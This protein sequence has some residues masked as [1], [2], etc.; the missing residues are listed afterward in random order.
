[1]KL[2]LTITLFF[3]FTSITLAQEKRV[4]I[5]GLVTSNNLAVENVHV[6]NSNNGF[7]EVT[8]F[9]GKFEILTNKGDTIK[10]S[11]IEYQKQEIVITDDIIKNGLAIILK[12]TINRLKEVTVRNH[13]L[14]RNIVID[15]MN[16]DNTIITRKHDLIDEMITLSKLPSKFDEITRIE[17]QYIYDVNAIKMS[18]GVGIGIE[19]RDKKSEL[20]RE[21]REKK[22]IPNQIINE[23]G[24]SYFIYELKISEDKIHNFLT[25]CNYRNIFELYKKKKIIRLIEILKIESVS[26]HKK[27]NKKNR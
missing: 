20:R 4:T 2:L 14:T 23:L 27:S 24:E 10:I 9:K 26:Y 21:L 17:S 19:I 11:H 7:G 15:N 18:G 8:N 1:M 12:R 6:L 13:N 16:T 25:Y 3:Y 22:S 5:S